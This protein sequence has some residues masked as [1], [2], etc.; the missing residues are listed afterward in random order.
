MSI[1]QST[2]KFCERPVYW[3]LHIKGTQSGTKGSSMPVDIE[4]VEDGNIVLSTNGTVIHYRVL[5]NGEM[6]KPGEK[7]RNSHFRTCP[8]WLA[9]KGKGKP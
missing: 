7:R 1:I 9:R 3:A 5:K 4:P 8:Q 2:C 6:L